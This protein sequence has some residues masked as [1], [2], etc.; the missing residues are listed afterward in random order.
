M[1]SIYVDDIRNPTE[2]FDSICRTTNDAVKIFRKK[3]KE[4]TRHFFLD[5][6]HD[7]GK[8]A[9]GGDFINI[10]KNIESYVK[11]GK[12]KNLDIDVHFH[13]MNPVGCENMRIIVRHCDY[14]QEVW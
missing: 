7:A 13:T 9:P 3:Y 14:M 6:D 11:C 1:Y 8:D 5:L 12:M 10:L 4:G 2:N